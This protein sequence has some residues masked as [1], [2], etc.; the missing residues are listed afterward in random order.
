MVMTYKRFL[1]SQEI[2]RSL[3]TNFSFP[4]NCN[5]SS[6]ARDSWE[7]CCQGFHPRQI[8]ILA[9]TCPGEQI[10]QIEF[11][12][13]ID[14]LHEISVKVSIFLSRLCSLLRMLSGKTI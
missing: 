12:T 14:I 4:G 6:L 11:P 8:Y 3:A 13:G 2:D 10:F 7:D 1:G 9:L 5:Y